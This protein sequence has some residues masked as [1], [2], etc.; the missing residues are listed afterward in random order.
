M[1]SK[2]CLGKTAPSAAIGTIA[3]SKGVKA[4]AV[5]IPISVL[6]RTY[7]I[8]VQGTTLANSGSLEQAMPRIS[9]QL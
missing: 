7:V 6:Q 8:L 4:S 3:H 5:P 2:E 1:K 9:S